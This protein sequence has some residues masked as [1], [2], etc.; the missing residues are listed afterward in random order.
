MATVLFC[1]HTKLSG[2]SR[3]S[4]DSSALPHLCKIMVTDQQNVVTQP[5]SVICFSK[6]FRIPSFELLPFSPILFE[7]W[8]PTWLLLTT[9]PPSQ[10]TSLPSAVHTFTCPFELFTSRICLSLFL[11]TIP[12][13][14]CLHPSRL[15]V[16]SIS[17]FY[18]NAQ[19]SYTIKNKTNRNVSQNSANSNCSCCSCPTAVPEITHSSFPRFSL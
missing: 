13:C 18:K 5:R 6:S 9:F 7:R 3:A 10:E 8:L 4:P 14:L 2:R 19:G 11:P 17:Y 15:L 1:D 12:L 16:S